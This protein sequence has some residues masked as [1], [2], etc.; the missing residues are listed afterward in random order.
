MA[1]EQKK[2]KK[3]KKDKKAKA[4]EALAQAQSEEVTED[5]AVDV[6]DEADL[7]P[8]VIFRADVPD[9]KMDV[10]TAEAINDLLRRLRSGEKLSLPHSRPMPSIGRRCHELRLSESNG[11]W[12]VFYRIDPDSIVVVHVLWKTT[13]Q[14]P[15]SDINL[16]K[17]RFKQYDDLLDLM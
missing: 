11:I 16:C 9:P 14:T 13:Q 4:A 10:P 6:P 7:K 1:R 12:R 3:N 2:P 17:S 5:E 8:V 15:K